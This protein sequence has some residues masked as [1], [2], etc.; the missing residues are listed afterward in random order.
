VAKKDQQTK[1]EDQVEE[2]IQ[3]QV[4]EAQQEPV[5]EEAQ[6]PV[7]QQEPVAEEAQA[8]V[9]DAGVYVTVTVPKAFKLR[10][11]HDHVVDYAAGIC[12][13]PV[14]HAEHWYSKAN[15]VTIYKK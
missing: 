1:V 5:A 9:V 3:E 14:E 13:M 10:T 2:Q 6:A 11:T 4:Q 7:E 15:G 8:P 12:E